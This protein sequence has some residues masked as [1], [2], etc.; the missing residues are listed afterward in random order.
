MEA[1]MRKGQYMKALGALAI[2]GV[3]MSGCAFHTSSASQANVGTLP[4]ILTQAQQRV[5]NNKGYL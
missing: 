1:Q 3:G 2:A 5:V 4:P